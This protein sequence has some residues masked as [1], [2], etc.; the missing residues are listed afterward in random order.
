MESLIGHIKNQVITNRWI[1][2]RVGSFEYDSQFN[3]SCFI[4]TN[5]EAT[6]Y[7]IPTFKRTQENSPIVIKNFIAFLIT[8][9]GKPESVIYNTYNDI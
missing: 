4:E 3:T 7:L 6:Q 5:Q 1:N 2:N 9:W 8:N